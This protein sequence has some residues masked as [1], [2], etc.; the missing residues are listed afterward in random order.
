MRGAQGSADPPRLV[1]KVAVPE[2]PD[3][4][5]QTLSRYF[6]SKNDIGLEDPEEVRVLSPGLDR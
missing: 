3:V 2:E 1:G 6:A 5:S 4:E